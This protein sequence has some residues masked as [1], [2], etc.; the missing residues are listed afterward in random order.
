MYREI[1]AAAGSRSMTQVAPQRFSRPSRLL[2][3]TRPPI[4]R[5]QR[6]Q[7]GDAAS[8]NRPERRVPPLAHRLISYF[9]AIVTPD[10]LLSPPSKK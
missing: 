2:S 6:F 9:T 5:S 10:W 4:S 3:Q 1:Q 7:F 8:A